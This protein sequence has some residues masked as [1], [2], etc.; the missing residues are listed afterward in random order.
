MSGLTLVS[1]NAAVTANA[2][3]ATT[4]TPSVTEQLRLEVQSDAFALL[5][6]IEQQY[7]YPARYPKGVQS[8]R[9]ELE[10][11]IPFL[12]SKTDLIAFSQRAFH[13]LYDHHSITGSG[14]ADAYGLVP[15][16]ADLWVEYVDGNY[17]VMDVRQGSPA[18]KAGIRPGS[19]VVSVEGRPIDEAV[20]H[21]VGPAYEHS[22]DERLAYAARVLL[23]GRRDRIRRIG[24]ER[25]GL[26]WTLELPNLYQ[27]RL[28]REAG[29]VA[30]SLYDVEDKTVGVIRLN[31]SLGNAKTIE[32]FDRALNDVA[33]ADGLVI[34]L[35]DTASGGNT[36]VARGI[37]SRFI[38]QPTVYQRHIL[39]NEERDFG[40]VR[41][42]LEEVHPRGEM[43]DKPVAV[44]SGRWTASMGEGLTV[45]FD[46]LG[47]PTFGTDMAGLLGGI[48]DHRLP[49][50]NVLVKLTT[51]QLQHVDGTPREDFHPRRYFEFADAP[52]ESGQDEPLDTAL[53]CVIGD[54]CE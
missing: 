10:G 26:E 14:L 5:Q 49:A 35:R 1:N 41:S 52:G 11:R 2:Q 28:V 31:D 47:I 53:Y 39:P 21:F 30:V 27:A 13:A 50:T 29:P 4:H 44:V 48:T 40:V 17:M 38:S 6:L 12:N 20:Q 43:Y 8:V 9:K 19:R 42:W 3:P 18:L 22:D 46:A 16:F 34:D 15:S 24:L 25:D 51:E 54:S 36:L 23:A 33:E 32:A 7:A 45:A 37:L